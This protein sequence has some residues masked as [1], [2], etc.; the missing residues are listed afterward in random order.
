MMSPIMW[1]Q[2]CHRVEVQLPP[3]QIPLLQEQWPNNTPSLQ[4]YR[5]YHPCHH[6]IRAHK[7]EANLT[8]RAARI[9]TITFSTGIIANFTNSIAVQLPPSLLGGQS[10][11]GFA[12][13]HTSPTLS[14]THRL[15]G[16]CTH[17]GAHEYNSMSR[18]PS[19]DQRLFCTG[20]T[21]QSVNDCTNRI[22]VRTG[23]AIAQPF[24]LEGWL[25]HQFNAGTVGILTAL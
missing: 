13:L 9:H 6:P 2:T 24:T 20:R 11:I 18:R 25:T 21:F 19:A 12:G 3:R 10:L 15:S 14:H 22:R 5:A 17:A 8:R 4:A 1:H 7:V 16:S 23:T